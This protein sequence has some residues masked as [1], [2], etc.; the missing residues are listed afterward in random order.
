MFQPPPNV[1]V[2]DVWIAGLILAFLVLMEAVVIIWLST[3][4]VF[5]KAK[6]RPQNTSND[7]DNS[8]NLP[9]KKGS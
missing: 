4:M 8:A 3:R 1:T 5:F 7:R 9:N 6:K 2:N